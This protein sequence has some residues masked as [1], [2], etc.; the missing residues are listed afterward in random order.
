M[1]ADEASRLLGG[2]DGWR[3]DGASLAVAE[4][5]AISGGSE[6]LECGT[7]DSLGATLANAMSNASFGLN[8]IEV[9]CTPCT[10]TRH[11]TLP[12]IDRPF[13]SVVSGDHRLGDRTVVLGCSLDE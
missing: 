9:C 3:M 1:T 11:G 10:L 12:G 13:S 2:S 5:S 6:L 8:E 7:P 4:K